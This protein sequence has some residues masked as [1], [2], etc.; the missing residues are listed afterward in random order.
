MVK[1]RGT[2]GLS[3]SRICR[4]VLRDV[5]TIQYI[6]T[7]TMRR[8]TARTVQRASAA[9]RIL[10]LLPVQVAHDADDEQRQQRKRG[11]RRRHREPPALRLDPQLVAVGGE[12]VRGR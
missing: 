3:D 9:L 8:I 6:G 7:D 2:Y 5:T 10:L 4:P 12:H 1:G 11:E